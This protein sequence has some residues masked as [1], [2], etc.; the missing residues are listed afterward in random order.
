MAGSPSLA[1][2]IHV[3]AITDV[4]NSLT[5]VASSLDS[6]SNLSSG[7]PPLHHLHQCPPAL[8]GSNKY[9]PQNNG[10]AG[11]SAD[12]YQCNI[13][14]SIEK[15]TNKLIAH[16]IIL[17]SITSSPSQTPP[18]SVRLLYDTTL[19]HSSKHGCHERR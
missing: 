9:R 18:S 6:T 16:I 17:H 15:I 19:S 10:M 8:G 3:L 5:N 13:M 2:L 4:I 12:A 7:R 1:S 11:P 14:I